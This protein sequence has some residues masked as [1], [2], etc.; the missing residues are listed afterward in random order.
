MKNIHSQDEVGEQEPPP[1]SWGRWESGE[2]VTLRRERR[3]RTGQGKKNGQ[4]AGHRGLSIP[5]ALLQDIVQTNPP[6]RV[7]NPL[8][9]IVAKLEWGVGSTD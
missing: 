5:A 3:E 8:P 4:E 7:Q 2:Q 9:P 6:I 1:P